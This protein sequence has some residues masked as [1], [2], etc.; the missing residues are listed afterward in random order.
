MYVGLK[1][2][3]FQPSSP[4]RHMTE[5]NQILT[6]QKDDNPILLLYTDGGQDHRVTYISVQLSLISIFFGER[7]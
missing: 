1:E 6:S 2:N 3:A 5:L 4:I 7:P